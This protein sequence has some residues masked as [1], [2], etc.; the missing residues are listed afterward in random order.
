MVGNTISGLSGH[1]ARTGNGPA[2]SH[3]GEPRKA[4]AQKPGTHATRLGVHW[5]QLGGCCSV[6]I[7]LMWD[8]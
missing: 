8:V 7:A 6:M 5:V 3:A 1:A 2:P 4:A